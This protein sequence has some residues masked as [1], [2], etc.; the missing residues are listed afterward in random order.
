MLITPYSNSSYLSA[1]DQSTLKSWTS[2]AHLHTYL[3]DF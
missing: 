1:V 2:I 3:A